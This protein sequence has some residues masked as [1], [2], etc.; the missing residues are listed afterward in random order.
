[1]NLLIFAD[2][3]LFASGLFALKGVLKIGCIFGAGNQDKRRS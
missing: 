3:S 2:R 1:M